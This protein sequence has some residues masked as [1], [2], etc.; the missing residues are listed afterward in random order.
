[1]ATSG[2][3]CG[4]REHRGIGERPGEGETCVLHAIDETCPELYGEGRKATDEH[5]Q[6][7][8]T[9]M[10]PTTSYVHTTSNIDNTSWRHHF[11]VQNDRRVLFSVGGMSAILC[12]C[13]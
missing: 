6:A 7:P 11:G 1:M 9:L 4:E 12:R 2:Q 3:P 8:I 10:N 13:K 5:R